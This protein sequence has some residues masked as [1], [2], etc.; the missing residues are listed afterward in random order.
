[1]FL[2]KRAAKLVIDTYITKFF[3]EN[4]IFNNQHRLENE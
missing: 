1:M 2:S 4:L 3:R